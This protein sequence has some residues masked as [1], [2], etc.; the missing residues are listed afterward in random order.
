MLASG[1][2]RSAQLL[3]LLTGFLSLLAFIGYLYDIHSLYKIF[4]YS[5]MALHTTISFMLLSCGTLLARP[6]RGYMA[7]INSNTAGGYMARRLLPAATLIPLLLGVAILN[8]QNQ[9]HYDPNFGMS[10]LVLASIVTLWAL[11]FWNSRSLYFVDRERKQTVKALEEAE[12][13]YRN[14]F[15]NAMEGIFQ[16]SPHGHMVTA[17]HAM[18]EMLGYHTQKELTA[19]ATSIGKQ[20]FADPNQ[21]V[22]LINQLNTLDSLEGFEVELMCRDESTIW[23]S[24]NIRR[25]RDSFG[26]LLY[27]EGSVVNITQRKQAEEERNRLAEQLQQAQKMESIGRFAGGIAHDFN[28]LLVPIMGY[29]DLELMTM[30]EGDQHYANLQQIKKAGERAAGLSRQILAFSRHQLLEMQVLDLNEVIGEF[31]P[32]LKCLIMENIELRVMREPNLKPV[33]ADKGQLEQVLMNLVVNGCDAM[34][35]GG[36][37]LIETANVHLDD[38]YAARHA[39][40]LSG[41][42]VMLA[43]SDTGLG[44]D[45]ETQK[46]IFEPFFTT[47][48]QGKGTGL[49]LATVFGIIKQHQGNLWVYSEPNRGTTFKIYLPQVFEESAAARQPLE[50]PLSLHGSETILVVEDELLVR[51]LVRETLETYGYD[52]LEASD[53]EEGL[54]IVAEYRQHLHLLITDIILPKQSGYELYQRLKEIH[55]ETGVLYMSGYTGNVIV[56][57]DILHESVNFLQKPFSVDKLLKKVRK[58]IL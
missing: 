48:E 42:Y 35:S 32:M 19:H 4:F 6:D 57:H 44:M 37:L 17:N 56:E 20:L 53:P 45:S 38:R 3:A 13:K 54:Q 46:R 28:N 23:A 52:V 31:E 43:V 1:K 36:K 39:E 51:S 22:H 34:P 30:P 29:V 8:G 55:P 7:I 24:I 9:R 16:W 58:S 25:V 40:T 50:A 11:I 14:I 5:S 27:Y 15:E 18:S 41:P 21:Y 49:G 26:N 12:Q 10:L 33:K 47:K 2:V